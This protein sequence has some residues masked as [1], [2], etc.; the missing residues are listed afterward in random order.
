MHCFLAL[1]DWALLY[2][3]RSSTTVAPN[4][5]VY[6]LFLG[7]AQCND[8]AL[9]YSVQP[10]VLLTCQLSAMVSSSQFGEKVAMQA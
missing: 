9:L 1:H 5:E 10:Q 6:A 7:F 3:I 4:M 8:W 2:S